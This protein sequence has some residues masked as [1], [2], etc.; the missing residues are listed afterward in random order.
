MVTGLLVDMIMIITLYTS[1]FINLCTLHI[2]QQPTVMTYQQTLF[3][4]DDGDDDDKIAY[5]LETYSL[6][7]S[8][9]PRA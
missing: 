5:E 2:T 7:Y 3:D 8:T 6:V 9:R 4:D 1:M